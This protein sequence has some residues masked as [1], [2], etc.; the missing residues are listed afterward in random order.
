MLFIC[1]PVISRMKDDGLSERLRQYSPMIDHPTGTTGGLAQIK[2][3]LT[4]AAAFKNPRK[5]ER[6]ERK[7]RTNEKHGI[8]SSIDHRVDGREEPKK[9][10]EKGTERRKQKFCTE[11]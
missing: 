1:A 2:Y 11:R 9:G 10:G 5:Y 6:G 3:R 8:R 4:L 7:R